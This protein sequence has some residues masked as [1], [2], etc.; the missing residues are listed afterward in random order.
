MLGQ[1]KPQDFELIELLV[2]EVAGVSRS[3]PS[4]S[5]QQ[6]SDFES[7]KARFQ[8]YIDQIPSYLHSVGKE[9]FFPHFFLGSFSILPDTKIAGK[10]GIKKVYFRFDTPKTLKIV[11]VIMIYLLT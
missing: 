6:K 4:T 11:V 3:G 9:G 8:S 5:A 2:R 1:E 7:F 10:L